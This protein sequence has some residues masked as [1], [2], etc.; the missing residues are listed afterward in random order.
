MFLLKIELFCSGMLVKLVAN[1]KVSKFKKMFFST[2][3]FQIVY[4]CKI[5]FKQLKYEFILK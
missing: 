4:S 3:A 5:V 1:N 2:F